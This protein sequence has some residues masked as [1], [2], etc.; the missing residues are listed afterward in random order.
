MCDR[1]I[2]VIHLG[3]EIVWENS[4]LEKNL[5]ITVNRLKVNFCR[6]ALRKGQMFSLSIKKMTSK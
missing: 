6:S 4:D 3:R 5:V 2:Q 1:S